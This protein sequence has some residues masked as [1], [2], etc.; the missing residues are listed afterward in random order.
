MSVYLPLYSKLKTIWNRNSVKD[1]IGGIISTK[2]D[3]DNSDY[4]NNNY[5]NNHNNNGN[6]QDNHNDHNETTKKRRRIF[7]RQNLF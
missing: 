5:D 1:D 2:L 7:V 3:E 6:N 4:D